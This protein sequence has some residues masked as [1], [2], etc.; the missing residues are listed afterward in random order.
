MVDDSTKPDG[1]Q[2]AVLKIQDFV[3]QVAGFE[4]TEAE[5]ADALQRYFVLK[6]INDHIVMARSYQ[7]PAA[8]D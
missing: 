1:I 3:K 7:G 8:G 2:Q 6:E 5:I 4:P